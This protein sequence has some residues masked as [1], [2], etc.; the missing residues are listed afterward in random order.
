MRE[1][2]NELYNLLYDLKKLICSIVIYTNENGHD[3]KDI[4]ELEVCTREKLK[5]LQGKI[6]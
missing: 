6:K 4:A 3:D 1:K 2:G 5:Q